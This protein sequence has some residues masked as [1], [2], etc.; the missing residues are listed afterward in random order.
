MDV[1]TEVS[2]KH[3]ENLKNANHENKG[4][5]EEECEIN[6]QKSDNAKA[7]AEK[8]VED[9]LTNPSIQEYMLNFHQINFPNKCS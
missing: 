4:K 1:D 8:L 6:L 5:E 2:A 9:F 3:N 7:H